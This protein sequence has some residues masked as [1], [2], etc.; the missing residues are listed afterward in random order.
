MSARET[1][2]T[3]DQMQH[4]TSTWGTILPGKGEQ[5]F[6]A[7]PCD[8]EFAV[9]KYTDKKSEYGKRLYSLLFQTF[10]VPF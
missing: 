9:I 7:F 3:K 10:S 5:V 4:I 1:L 8:S 2:Y 6:V